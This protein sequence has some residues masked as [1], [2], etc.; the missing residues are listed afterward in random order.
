MT[1]LAQDT[2][3]SAK[4]LAQQVAKQMA[5]EPLETLKDVKE[6]VTGVKIS[7]QQ[8]V[9]NADDSEN[10]KKLVEHQNDLQDRMKSSRRMEALDRELEEIR[11]QKLFSDLQRRISEGEEIPL[12]DYPE[13]SMEQKQVPKAQM[14]AVR[15]QMENAKSENGKSFVEPASKKGR[16]LFNFGKKQA[17]K[18]EQTRVEKPVPPSG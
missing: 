14:E 3:Q 12:E 17:V 10:Q 15:V 4:S 16:Q 7:E 9:K 11:K 6:Q 18:N 8:S 2:T 13:L 1:G 5:R